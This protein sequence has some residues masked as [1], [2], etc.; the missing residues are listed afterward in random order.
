MDAK[1][2]RHLLKVVFQGCADTAVRRQYIMITPKILT[3]MDYP[4]HVL[5]HTV[6]NGPE[7]QSSSRMSF[8]QQI[9]KLRKRQRLQ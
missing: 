3:K 6:Y 4:E 9:E 2:E 7:I 5:V 1:N 8:H